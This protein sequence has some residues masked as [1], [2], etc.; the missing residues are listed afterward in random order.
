QADMVNNRFDARSREVK[1]DLARAKNAKDVKEK[2]VAQLMKQY[3]ELFREAKYTEAEMVALR[4]KE[5][6]P[7]NPMATAAVSMARLQ[8]SRAQYEGIHESNKDVFKEAL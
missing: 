5:L 3:N 7:D 6:D 4:V 1:R 2:N 8:R